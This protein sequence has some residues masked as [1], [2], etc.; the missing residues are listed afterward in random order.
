MSR[1]LARV[2]V[3][4]YPIIEILLIFWVGRTIGWGWTLLLLA[5]GLVIGLLLMRAA[6]ITAFRAVAA[7]ARRAQPYVE[8]DEVTGVARTVHPEPT[9]SQ[10]DMEQAGAEIRQSGWLF[11][12]GLFFAVPGFLS[13]L[14]GAL[15]LL[16]AIRRPLAARSSSGMV[17]V[18]ETIVTEDPGPAG[19]PTAPPGGP[20]PSGPPVIRGEILPPKE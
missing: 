19:P 13:D 11:V 15:L 7:P 18:G 8:I 12:S 1:F 2:A 10:A 9:M 4:A 3:I 6:G 5:A 14:F 20:A 17:I 16:P